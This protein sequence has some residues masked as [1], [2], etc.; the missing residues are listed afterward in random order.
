[1]L[2]PARKTTVFSSATVSN[3]TPLLVLNVFAGERLLC[4]ENTMLARIVLYG[5]NK[6]ATPD[7]ADNDRVR[8]HAHM[9]RLK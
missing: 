5:I 6:V 4:K 2:R 8:V 9:S 3:E 7:N 1:M